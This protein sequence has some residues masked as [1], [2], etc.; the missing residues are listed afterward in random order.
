M[1]GKDGSGNRVDGYRCEQVYSP[2][3]DTYLL[4][5]AVLHELSCADRVLEV[6]CGSGEIAARIAE[7]APVIA[8]DINPHAVIAAAMRGVEVVRTDLYAGIC[9]EFDLVLFNPPYL[10]T[11]EEDRLN[12]WL[13]Y[14]LDG[15][16]S[17]REV[18][19]RFIAGVDR[20]LAPRGRILLL[21]S[22]LTGL[23][24]V[25]HI[26]AGH[27]FLVFIVAAR[28]VEDETLYVLR[29]TRDLC[30]CRA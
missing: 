27:G 18:I 19:A 5:E 3:Q 24:E 2:E 30:R 4:L 17:G 29:G 6:G 22:S 13:E 26:F 25:Q 28:Q 1:H 15:G 8:T 10:P 23:E 12:D 20:V 14:A 9:G 11:C 16:E 21:A 7:I